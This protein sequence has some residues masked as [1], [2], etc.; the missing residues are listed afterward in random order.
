[1]SI[2]VDLQIATTHPNYP[3]AAMVKKWVSTALKHIAVG[4][5]LSVRIVDE[6]EMTELN[7]QYRQ[8][9]KPTNVLSFPCTLPKAIRGDIL[10]DLV[11]CAPVIEQEAHDQQKTL[12]A[13]WAHM[14]VHGVLHLCGYDHEN[15]QD[16]ANMESTEITILSELGFPNPYKVETI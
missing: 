9:Q 14:L 15:E 10:G 1:M 8:K 4:G 2:R 3:T 7:F 5:Q 11:I 6:A 13:H 16:A 12:P